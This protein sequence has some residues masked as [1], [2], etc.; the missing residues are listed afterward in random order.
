MAFAT[1]EGAQVQGSLDLNAVPETPVERAPAAPKASP[2][3]TPKPSASAI[4]IEDK[5]GTLVARPAPAQTV[6]ESAPGATVQLGAFPSQDSAR[7]TWE[8]M[9]KRFGYLAEKGQS[10]VKADVNGR[11]FYRLRVGTASPA[12]AK[13]ICARLRVAGENCL[14]VN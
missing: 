7:K 6:T 5:G 3:A 10:I 11:T 1:S 4:I 9:S 8:S 13:D 2:T 14:V 12:E